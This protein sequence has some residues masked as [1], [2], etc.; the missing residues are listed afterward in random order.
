M[1]LIFLSQLEALNR[2]YR[3]DCEEDNTYQDYY[4]PYCLYHVPFNFPKGIPSK[5]LKC[6]PKTG[7]ECRE[8]S[9]SSIYLGYLD[10][11]FKKYLPNL[12]QQLEYCSQYIDCACLWPE[13][14][15]EAAQISDTAY[16]L[17]RDLI[18]TTA[19][20]NLI[21]NERDQRK[22]VENPCWFLNKHGLTISFI[23]HQFRF[24]DYY[25]ICRDI[26]NFAISKYEERETAKINDRLQD[27]LEALYP[28]F[29]ELY[30]SCYKKHPNPE[31]AQ[32]IRFMKFLV[33]DISGLDKIISSK[34]LFISLPAPNS[35]NF[36]EFIVANLHTADLPV[37]LERKGVYKHSN[38][39]LKKNYSQ[40]L[41]LVKSTTPFS[42]QSDIFLEQGTM[43]NDL[44]LYKEAIQVLTQVIQLSPSN[45]DAY[46]E[47]AMAYFETNQLSLALKDY[48]SAKKLTILPPFK[49]SHHKAMVMQA[50]YIPENKTEFSKGLVSGTVDGAKVSAVEFIPSIFS[51]CRGISNGLWAFVCSPIEVSQEMVNTAYSIGEFISSHNTEECFQCIVPELKELSLSWDNLNDN[52]RGQKIGFIIGKYGVDIFAPVGA[53]KGMNKV[54][55]LKRANTMCTLENCV[56]SEIKQAKILEESVRRASIRE[57]IISESV[58][59]SK[60]LVRNSNAQIHIM[61]PKHAW[62]KLI[63]MSGNVE[64]DF[65]KVV[66]LLEDNQIFLEK[67]RLNPTETFEKLVR[68][69]HQMKINGLEVKAIFNKNLETGEIFLNDAWV[70]TK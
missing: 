17:F 60:I 47:R 54:R 23:V 9:S 42:P 27:I 16:L 12:K 52:S 49:P 59:N 61:Q 33:R 34:S 36:S 51:C 58:K 28:K 8:C 37:E 21:E 38:P 56:A 3:F 20:S 11:D 32:E 15:L 41:S 40:F 24:S 43:L 29:F 48:E 65:K 18:S 7:P 31:I 13:Y 46:I 63:K 14:S 5:L 69:N 66:K 22:L 35:Y 39:T 30:S 4:Y 19:L 45:R 26:E 2:D 70:I 68:Y 1:T 50:I 53:L 62:D 25:R 10:L 44:L 57:K 64:E 67:H 6:I 55:A